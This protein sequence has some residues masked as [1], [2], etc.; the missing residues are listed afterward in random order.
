MFLSGNEALEVFN[1]A[2]G[3]MT[4]KTEKSRSAAPRQADSGF[5]NSVN[6]A[7]K[8]KNIGVYIFFHRKSTQ[9]IGIKV[10][11]RLKYKC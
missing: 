6:K 10:L 1:R 8:T 7:E 11:D 3:R 5:K 9:S 2:R 4:P